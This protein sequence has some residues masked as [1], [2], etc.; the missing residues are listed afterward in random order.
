MKTS[1]LVYIY[2]FQMTFNQHPTSTAGPSLAGVLGKMTLKNGDLRQVTWG[3]SR[4]QIQQV[5]I[6]MAK[7]EP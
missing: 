6:S 2:P 1:I 5:R 4:N 7:Q 3:D